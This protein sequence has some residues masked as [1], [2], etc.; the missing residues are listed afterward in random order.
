MTGGAG[1]LENLLG[2]CALQAVTALDDALAATSGLGPADRA[3]L[4]SLLNYGDGENIDTLRRGLRL[5]QPGSA[6]AVERLVRLG[7]AERRRSTADR[8][9][10][11][12]VLTE[13]G[14]RRARELLAAR[15]AVL[16]ELLAP[17]G[18]DERAALEA[19]FA[20]LLGAAAR[21]VDAARHV[22]RL[23]DTAACG[24]P[25]HCP[26]TRSVPAPEDPAPGR[27]SPH[28]RPL[29]RYN[30]GGRRA[31]EETCSDP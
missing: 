31:E 3:A 8:R 14:E 12:L 11:V 19:T 17:L 22:C 21:D 26:V 2:A 4:V 9:A 28:D 27:P 13:A 25:D 18:P 30:P 6:H 10:A 7:L 23:C 24:H 5:S 15:R 29:R 1:R 16:G 20:T